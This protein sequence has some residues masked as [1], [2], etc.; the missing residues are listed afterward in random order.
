MPNLGKNYDVTFLIARLTTNVF[1]TKIFNWQSSIPAFDLL[2]IISFIFMYSKQPNGLAF[3]LLPEIFDGQYKLNGD[4]L[5]F[6]KIP[7]DNNDFIPDTLLVSIKD[8]AL[9][10]EKDNN[11][12]FR[13]K[14]EW[15]NHFKIIY[16]KNNKAI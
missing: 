6:K 9:F 4:T 8:S 16:C 3:K 7:Y 12:D 5:I 1:I 11:G 2:L 15:L 14:K 13:K 10:I